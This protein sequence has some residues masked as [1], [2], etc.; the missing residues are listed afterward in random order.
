[1]KYA[2][3][4]S[5]QGSQFKGMAKDICDNSVAARN[6][7]NK[8]SKITGE[9]IP[10]LLWD[11][12]E[13]ILSRSDKS[14]IA[15]STMSL[16]I[17]AALKEKG[18]EP[19]AVAGFSLGEFPALYTAGV[20]DFETMV[21]VV[22]QRGNVMQKCCEEIASNNA[23]AAPGMAAVIGLSP[24]KVVEIC[25]PLSEKGLLFAANLNSP[26]QTVVSGTYEG[27]R[28]GETLMKEA[29]AKRYITLA[30]AGPFHSPLMSSAS[31][32]FRKI[33]EQVEF[34]N[35]KIPLFANVTGKLVSSG[36]EAK[37]NA[38]LHLTHSLLWTD[39]EKVLA[40]TMSKSGNEWQVVECGA[41]KVLFGFWRDSGFNYTKNDDGTSSGW[42]CK[43][44]GTWDHIS[45]L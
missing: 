41:G 32:E 23:G 22:Q 35:P 34:H 3:L 19:S 37:Q 20:L 4:F 9:D 1:M 29:G 45:V 30:V 44:A 7:V 33:L 25:K 39:V 10:A 16:A 2:Y 28:L 14:Q 11:T 40:D 27:I 38:L 5:G 17:V 42:E 43:L 21:K 36:Q 6:I 12:E 18:I 8:V 13:K 24:E 26:K 31:E 15:I